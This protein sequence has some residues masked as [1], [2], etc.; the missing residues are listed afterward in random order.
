[1]DFKLPQSEQQALSDLREI[2]LWEGESAWEYNQKFKDAIGRLAHPIYEEH[3]IEWYIHGFL[4]LT[5]IMLMQ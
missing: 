4:P 3:Q 1:M 5:Q 2:Q